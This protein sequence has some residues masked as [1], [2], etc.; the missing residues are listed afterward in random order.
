MYSPLSRLVHQ[1]HVSNIYSY[2]L[3]YEMS[4]ATLMN[5]LGDEKAQRC[6]CAKKHICLL[7]QTISYAIFKKCFLTFPL[8]AAISCKFLNRTVSL[9][10]KNRIIW[11]SADLKFTSI[12]RNKKWI[13]STVK[14]PVA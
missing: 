7:K 14:N 13:S 10:T 8:I 9:A 6:L 2:I 5:T 3:F 4:A 1:N 11:M 12:F